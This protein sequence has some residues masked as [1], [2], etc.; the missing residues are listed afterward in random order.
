L[1]KIQYYYIITK[2]AKKCEVGIFYAI[3]GGGGLL[4]NKGAISF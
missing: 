4:E 1:Q 2:Y 3:R